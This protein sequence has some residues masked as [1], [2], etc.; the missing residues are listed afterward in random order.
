[1]KTLSRYPLFIAI[2]A[3][4]ASRLCAGFQSFK[5]EP[6]YVPPLSPVLQ[7]EGITEGRV[8]FAIDVSAK[9]ELTDSLLIGYTHPAL[10]RPCW[11]ALKQWKFTPATRDGQPVGVQS[12]LA[13]DYTAEGVVISRSAMVDLDQHLGRMF[14][15][16]LT[17][18][19]RSSD[20]LDVAPRP[21][22]ASMPRYALQAAKEGVRGTVRVHFYI[23]ETGAVR[24]P[25]IEGDAHPY[26]SE[27]AV[28]AVKNWRFNPPISRGKPVLIAARQDFNFNQ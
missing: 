8:I 15:N 3:L 4:A 27:M 21:I 1:M 17:L 5:V 12:E 26:L 23:D 11:E 24:M 22:S 9:G 20:E 7:M 16:R 14:G 13:I 19:R 28:N 2:G 18:A 6:T 25:S 10:V